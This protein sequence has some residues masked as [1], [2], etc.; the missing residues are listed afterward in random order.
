M[1]LVIIWITSLTGT[2]IKRVIKLQT[3]TKSF[4]GKRGFY[5]RLGQLQ[6]NSHL[7]QNEESR[8]NEDVLM[9]FSLQR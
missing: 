9:G 3:T 5:C 7:Q 1:L 2:V 6:I 4:L 8:L